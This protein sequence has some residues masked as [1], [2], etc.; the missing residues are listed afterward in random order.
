MRLR[1]INVDRE[2]T[3]R[4]D[5]FLYVSEVAELLRMDPM[6]IYRAIRDREFPAIRVRGW[7]VV[8]AMAIDEMETAAVTGNALVDAAEW[9]TGTRVEPAALGGA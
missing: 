8:P 4:A 1:K 9:A 3:V 5:R 7:I 6:T 2:S